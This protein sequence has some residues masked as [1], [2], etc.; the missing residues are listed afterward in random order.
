ME[1]IRR[2]AYLER[3]RPFMDTDLVKVLTGI[4]RCGKS[5]LMAQIR[6][7]LLSRGVPQDRCI[8][9]NFE[10]MEND[11]LR[12]AK[13]LHDEVMRR[14]QSVEGRVYLFFDEI[15]EVE[16]WERCIDSLRVDL[17]CDVYLTGSNARLLSGELATYLTGRYVEIPI[18]PF[19]F[20]EF[21]QAYRAAR[22]EVG[23]REAF[24]AYVR[25]GGM[26]YLAQLG[27]Q[28]LPSFEYLR[29]VLDSIELKD[30][31]RRNGIRDADLLDRILRFA[32]SNMGSTFS[33]NSIARFLKSE[34]RRVAPETAINYLR[35]CCDAFVCQRV[36]RW[37]VSGKQLLS[38]NEKYYAADHGFREA[39]FGR[40]E[41][42]INA[43][44]ENIVYLELVR[45]GYAVTVGRLDDREVDFV[46]EGGREG[47]GRVYIQVAYLLASEETIDRE[48]GVLLDIPDN[49]PK[50]V[51]SLDEFDLGREGVRHLNI[52]DFLLSGTPLG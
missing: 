35:A 50:Y 19:S 16:S 28:E 5:V 38:V 31:V 12:T 29:T 21:E 30:I 6:D 49:F 22:P 52:R 40:N 36:D 18:F 25:F 13:A 24:N 33:A 11:R 20:S 34:R 48:F 39:L 1:T 44:L 7:E 2:T 14:A 51:L 4:R 46:C 17:D 15:Q 10:Q 23:E 43:V 26:P 8:A 32:L 42:D 45:R 47:Q 3:I 41:R 9:L 27:Y 37:D